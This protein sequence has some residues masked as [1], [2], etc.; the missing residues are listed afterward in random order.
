MQ[1]VYNVALVRLAMHQAALE[2]VK[3]ALLKGEAL[4]GLATIPLLVALAAIAEPLLEFVLG[5]S[6]ESTGQL[7]LGPLVG[8]FL[9]VRQILPTTALRAIGISG[10]SLTATVISAVTAGVGLIL[11]GHISPLAISAVYALSILPGYA[12]IH[13]VASRKLSIPMERGVLDLCRDLTLAIAAFALAHAITAELRDPSLLVQ[14][15]VAGCSAFLLAGTALTIVQRNF[16]RS[17]FKPSSSPSFAR[18]KS[19]D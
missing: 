10:V 2:R 12:V 4:F 9:L 11:F 13:L 8:S 15:V 6:W 5:A 16:F 19:D 1:A 14:I 3:D 7:V 17:L 18:M